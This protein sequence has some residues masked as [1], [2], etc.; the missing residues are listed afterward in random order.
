MRSGCVHKCCC[1][2][3]KDKFPTSM[4]ALI[5]CSSGR[6]MWDVN[7]TCWWTDQVN[8]RA[9]EVL[10]IVQ[11]TESRSSVQPPSLPTVV[12]DQ[13]PRF[14]KEKPSSNPS[15]GEALEMVHQKRRT[16]AHVLS[17][18]RAQI[19]DR[20]L[21]VAVAASPPLNG[22]GPRVL[23]QCVGGHTWAPARRSEKK[24]RLRP[25]FTEPRVS[26]ATASW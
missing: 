21:Q 26:S 3:G 15:H 10:R 18:F 4:Q 22:S 16:L 11:E 2:R 19:W 8:F 25:G 6:V 1:S 14:C 5:C 9:S 24:P 13:L 17:V 7:A 23:V 12:I 20:Q